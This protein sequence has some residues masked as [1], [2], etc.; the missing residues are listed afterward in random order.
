M[1]NIINM[2]ITNI[3]FDEVFHSI[4][5]II[6][7]KRKILYVILVVEFFVQLIATY[8]TKIIA[9]FREE[10]RIQIFFS[11]F[12]CHWFAWLQNCINSSKTI[13][14]CRFII[15]RTFFDKFNFL[16]FKTIYNHLRIEGCIFVIW[17]LSSIKCYNTDT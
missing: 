10:K 13:F 8:T 9:A 6:F 14:F 3:N 11:L 12:N 16:A 5:D 1:V 15:N 7:N 2:F 17:I 4:D